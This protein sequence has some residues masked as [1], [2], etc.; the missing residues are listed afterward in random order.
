MEEADAAMARALGQL[1][2]DVRARTM[3]ANNQVSTN[4]RGNDVASMEEEANM[5]M[6]RAQGQR[7][8]T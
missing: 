4:T 3:T 2:G 5:A 1:G 7:G 8:G 6:A